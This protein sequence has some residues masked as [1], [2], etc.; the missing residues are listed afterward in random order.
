MR[1]REAPLLLHSLVAREASAR[2][3]RSAR[4]VSLLTAVAAFAFALP[5]AAG[6]PAVK[7]ANGRF[8]V[9][10]DYAHVN[11][12]DVFRFTPAPTTLTRADES[13]TDLVSFTGFYTLPV[14]DQFG[15]RVYGSIN[16]S[17]V[18][19]DGL[20]DLR[21]TGLLMGAD[22]FWRDPAV[23]EF[24]AGT[25]YEF[26]DSELFRSEIDF[27]VTDK[28]EHTAGVR[29]YGKLFLDQILGFGP[30]DLDLSGRFSD[31]DI[32]DNGSFSAERT[33]SAR[34]GAKLYFSDN[35]SFRAGGAWTR[36]NFGSATFI[37]DRVFE[38][39]ARLLVPSMPSVTIG[40]GFFIGQRE[41][42][43]RTFQNFGR[44]YGGLRVQVDVSFP[45]ATSLVELNRRY[46]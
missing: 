41:E 10:Y 15:T 7:E 2:R 32:D 39:D 9:G 30:I 12:D 16:W 17:K 20:D 1:P 34:G 4:L 43:P 22:A 6:D 19:V 14:A 23:G 25:F 21:S 31:S 38:A 35:F 45:G 13:D 18:H 44:Q 27:T 33:Y 5:A 42:S 8:I 29:A 36:T 37:E 40:A 28:S 3:C 26:R 11:A 24:G 46:F